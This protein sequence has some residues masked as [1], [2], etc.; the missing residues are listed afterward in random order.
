MIRA[1]GRDFK[2]MTW[3][4]TKQSLRDFYSSDLVC[5]QVGLLMNLM[6]CLWEFPKD[7]PQG[8]SNPLGGKE[9]DIPSSSA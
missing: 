8:L 1:I 3:N 6:T 5:Q 9:I 2:P 7:W 4:I